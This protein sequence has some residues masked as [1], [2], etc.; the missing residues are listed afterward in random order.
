MTID[1]QDDSNTI[2]YCKVK[3]RVK[4]VHFEEFKH[5]RDLHIINFYKEKKNVCVTLFII[6]KI[7]N[8]Y[9]HKS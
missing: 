1:R 3:F 6:Y 5:S 9:A 4:K 2:H 8:L 7:E